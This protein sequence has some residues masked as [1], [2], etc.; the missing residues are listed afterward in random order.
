[1]SIEELF[2]K[3]SKDIIDESNPKAQESALTEVIV[4]LLNEVQ[5]I[6][7]K[8]KYHKKKE[9]KSVIEEINNKYVL[10]VE[11]INEAADKD[12]L[13]DNGFKMVTD[14]KFKLFL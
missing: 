3:Y 1:M 12:L 13:K 8:N 10:F 7:D 5:E 14:K 11:K 6:V 4:L 9:I 2:E